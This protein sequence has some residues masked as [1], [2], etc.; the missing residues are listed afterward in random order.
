MLEGLRAAGVAMVRVLRGV[1]GV[2]LAWEVGAQHRIT[3]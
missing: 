2:E 1:G 3:E